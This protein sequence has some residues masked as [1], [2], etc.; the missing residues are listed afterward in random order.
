KSITDNLYGKTVQSSYD[1]NGFVTSIQY[2]GKTYNYTYDEAGRLKT[3]TIDG[4]TK[5]YTYN[6]YNTILSVNTSGNI[7]GYNY[8]SF[9]RITSYIDNNNVANYFR[10]DA[11]GN[12]V[13]YKGASST[14]VDNMVWTQGRKLES[15]TLNGNEFS[16]AYDM[17]GMRYKKNV[18]GNVTE[19]YLD[20]SKIIAECYKEGVMTFLN[21]YIYDMTGIAGMTYCGEPYYFEKNTLGDVIG[22]RKRDGLLVATYTY[23]AWGNILTK[24]GTMADIN[25]FRYRGYYYDNETGFY[26]LQSRYYDP[27]T[28]M[29]INADNYEIVSTLAQTVGQ[30]NMY[31]Y[32]GNNPIMF[33]DNKGESITL[34]LGLALITTITLLGGVNGAF[35]AEFSGGN[36]YNGLFAGMLAGLANAILV[37]FDK[38]ILGRVVGSIIFDIVY[39]FFENGKPTAADWTNLFIDVTMDVAFISVYVNLFDSSNRLYNRIIATILSSTVDSFIDVVQTYH[40]YNL[41][42]EQIDNLLNKNETKNLYIVADN[43]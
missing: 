12:P 27:S 43:L 4:A 23:D 34:G 41:N 18:N 36:W 40:I 13:M 32:C 35:C 26:Y 15:G 16:Y 11:M 22:I 38:P 9:G 24:S 14:A 19:Y 10:Y 7:S 6:Q 3:E 17:N 20:G 8:D 25:P 42:T 37:C 28:R 1:S 5:E 39:P 31:A 33:T 29:F 2:N 21:Y 30:L